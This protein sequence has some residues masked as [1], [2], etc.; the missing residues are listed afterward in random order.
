MLRSPG[1]LR[2]RV[3][4]LDL[5]AATEARDLFDADAVHHRAVRRAQVLDVG[6][7]AAP[8]HP[9]VDLR[10]EGVVLEH[11]P[12]ARGAADGDLVVEGVDLARARRRVEYPQHHPAA[13]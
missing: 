1:D 4:E 13:R 3:A 12:A 6:L 7:A 2:E 8:E 5:I 11:D 9:R 10:D